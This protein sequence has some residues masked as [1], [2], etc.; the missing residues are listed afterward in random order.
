MWRSKGA[1]SSWAKKSFSGALASGR[2]APATSEGKG[3]IRDR[4]L[5]GVVTSPSYRQRPRV[6]LATFVVHVLPTKLDE[7]ANPKSRAERDNNQGV[8]LGLE[9]QDGR[10]DQ[11]VRSAESSSRSGSSTISTS[12]APSSSPCSKAKS[13]ARSSRSPSFAT[14]SVLVCARHRTFRDGAVRVPVDET[15]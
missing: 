7:L 3:R 14:R 13:A 1:C 9:V 12:G 11:A 5:L 2:R 8:P 6:K 4:P 10:E 15:G